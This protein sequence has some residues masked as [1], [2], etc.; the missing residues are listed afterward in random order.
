MAKSNIIKVNSKNCKVTE[1]QNSLG[2]KELLEIIKSNSSAEAGPHGAGDTGM[3]PSGFG[4][5]PEREN[6]DLPG[7]PVQCSATL[8]V[9][10]LFLS[11]R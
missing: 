7:Q 2:W 3:H 11:L 8:N 1:P 10:K 4:M 6:P 9:K 5:P